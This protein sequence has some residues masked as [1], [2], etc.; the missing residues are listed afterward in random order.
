MI[1]SIQQEQLMSNQGIFSFFF[2]L[3]YRPYEK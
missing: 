1:I 2:S 3:Q